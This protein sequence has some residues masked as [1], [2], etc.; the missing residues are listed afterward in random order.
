MPPKILFK[1]GGGALLLAVIVFSLSTYW[2]TTRTF[3]PLDMP[4]R[5]DQGKLQSGAF[6]INLRERYYVNVVLDRSIDDYYEDRCN[7]KRVFGS[8]WKLYRQ[9]G[10]DPK[11]VELLVSWEDND[12]QRSHVGDF[13]AGPGTYQL[14]WQGPAGAGCLNT[15]HPRLRVSTDSS[16]YDTAFGFVLLGCWLVAWVGAGAFSRAIVVWVQ[17]ILGNTRALR[18]FP[19]M[20]VTNVIPVRRH[21]P[22]P[23]IKDFPNFGLVYGFILW[24]FVVSLHDFSAQTV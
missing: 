11:N 21:R 16:S 1:I 6:E 12:T 15:R 5:L 4:I 24:V 18:I 7:Y 8:Q 9:T 10:A 22:V 17:G 23:Q 20:A 3:E 14:E 13:A 2:W 19:D